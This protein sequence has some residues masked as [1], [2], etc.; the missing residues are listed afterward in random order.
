MG[1]LDNY[2]GTSAVR[3]TPDAG[4][5]SD[6][7]VAIDLTRDEAIVEIADNGGADLILTSRAGLLGAST[8]QLRTKRAIDVIG[9]ALGMIV[10]S[11][12][13]LV[14]AAGVKL[15]SRGPVFYRR[16]RIGKDGE[17]FTFV[18]FRTMYIKS[19]EAKQALLPLNEVDGPIFKIKNDPRIT[20]FGRFL[21]KTSLDELPQLMHVLSG[22]MSLVGVRPQLPEEVAAYT[23]THAQRLLVKPGL[24][25]IWQV[26]GRSDLDFETWMRM[27]LEYIAT[28][29]PGLDAK[30]LL[31][32]VGAV[33]SG[34]GAY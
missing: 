9:A 30:L 8:T 5:V 18:K 1:S 26:S 21:R 13:F 14:L 3:K 33:I 19:D 7:N 16:P 32:T 24:T 25:C 17:P 28:W 15:T 6:S 2:V 34:R 23:E 10:L 4:Q 29:T 20:P 31:K 22:K 27:D 11:P 12:L